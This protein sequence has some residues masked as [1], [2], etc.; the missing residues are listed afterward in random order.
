MS[1][2]GLGTPLNMCRAAIVKSF[3]LKHVESHL[4]SHFVFILHPVSKGLQS[5][6]NENNIT[7]SS[8]W[9]WVFTF[10]QLNR[11]WLAS[12]PQQ[13]IYNN[14]ITF[15]H[16]PVFKKKKAQTCPY[17]YQSSSKSVTGCWFPVSSTSVKSLL[18]EASIK[19]KPEVWLW[20][21]PSHT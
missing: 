1:K 7:S 14:K 20:R 11:H 19:H 13:S 8:S 6:Y 21:D 12:L 9:V 18:Q 15:S 5:K 4:C 16:L 3:W 2:T 17:T 10:C